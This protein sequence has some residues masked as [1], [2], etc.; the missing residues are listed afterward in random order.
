MFWRPHWQAGFVVSGVTSNELFRVRNVFLS[1]FWGSLLLNQ[2]N[3]IVAMARLPQVVGTCIRVHTHEFIRIFLYHELL[4]QSVFFVFFILHHS[5]LLCE[6]CFE[7]RWQYISCREITEY[8]TWNGFLSL[9]FFTFLAIVVNTFLFFS[10]GSFYL[11]AQSKLKTADTFNWD[12]WTTIECHMTLVELD[13]SFIH[14]PAEHLWPNHCC[15]S[16]V[17]WYKIL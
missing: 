4:G 5:V 14:C 10:K 16:L 12:V 17:I 8:L 15:F 3:T 6:F 2:F 11:P 13:Y 9:C 1:P 7:F